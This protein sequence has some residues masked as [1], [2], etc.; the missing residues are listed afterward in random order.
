MLIC[1]P[2]TGKPAEGLLLLLLSLSWLLLLLPWASIG[3]EAVLPGW[4]GP[5]AWLLLGL[6]PCRL[7][8]LL[9]L[10]LVVTRVVAVA[11][12]AA[13]NSRLTGRVRRKKMPM[14]TW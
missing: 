12:A 8:L 10:L 13:S 11:M 9:L 3:G 14:N 5:A 4:L 6:L 2:R 7:L 1:T